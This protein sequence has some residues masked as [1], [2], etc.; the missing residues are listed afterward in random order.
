MEGMP[1][2]C[3]N[4]PWTMNASPGQ[5]LLLLIPTGVPESWFGWCLH[6]WTVSDGPENSTKGAPQKKKQFGRVRT[7]PDGY[8]LDG[9][10]RLLDGNSRV[11]DG[12]VDGP[13]NLNT[14]KVLSGKKGTDPHNSFLLAASPP[15][16]Y[17]LGPLGSQRAIQVEG[18]VSCCPSSSEP[19]LRGCLQPTD[20]PSHSERRG[21]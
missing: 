2:T 18:A 4:N 15:L 16:D 14:K 7:P 10:F 9:Y 19:L 20:L 1:G 12:F 3:L 17:P 11:S 13:G 8:V 6:A 5:V 21:R